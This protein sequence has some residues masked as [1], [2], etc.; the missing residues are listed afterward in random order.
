MQLSFFSPL[1][2]PNDCHNRFLFSWLLCDI[3]LSKVNAT[4]V[5]DSGPFLW[6]NRYP[7]LVIRV[8]LT[9]VLVAERLLFGDAVSEEVW[10]WTKMD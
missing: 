8:T 5:F 6:R 4:F 1:I 10:H 7:P 9:L 3:D 2:I